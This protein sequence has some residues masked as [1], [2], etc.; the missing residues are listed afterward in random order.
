MENNTLGSTINTREE[1]GDTNRKKIGDSLFYLGLIVLVLGVLF[2]KSKDENDGPRSLFGYSAFLVLTSSMEDV[3]PKDSFVIT[4][5]V[6]P[7]TLK[8]GDDITYLYQKGTTITHRIVEITE[9]DKQTGIRSF[10]TKG[11]MNEQIDDKRVHAQNIVGKVIYHNYQIG[12]ILIIMRKNW[13]IAVTLVILCIGF[14]R[15]LRIVFSKTE[16]KDEKV[17]EKGK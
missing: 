6:D 1:D 3:L 8:I 14:Y 16:Q 17:K 13:Y 9:H 5:M 12:Y 11:T 15:S 7:N 4:K 2:I 10:R